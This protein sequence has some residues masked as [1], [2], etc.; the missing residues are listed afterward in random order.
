M[1]KEEFLKR[2]EQLLSDISEERERMH[3]PFTEVILRM[4]ELEMRH[5]S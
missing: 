2:L 3:L 5:R 4:P 1:N